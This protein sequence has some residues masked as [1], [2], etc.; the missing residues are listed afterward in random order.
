LEEE[1]AMFTGDNVLGQ[2]TTAVEHLGTW[3]ESLRTMQSHECIKG[4]PAHGDVITNINSKIAGE[5]GAKLRRER[6]VLRALRQV[7][8]GPRGTRLSTKEVAMTVHTGRISESLMEKAL[9]PF[10]DEVLRKLAEDGMV[11]FDMRGGVKKWFA[12]T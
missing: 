10:M 12:V 9:E 3:M 4:Y 7:E 6:Q 2:G 5:L 1:N 11:G 8:T